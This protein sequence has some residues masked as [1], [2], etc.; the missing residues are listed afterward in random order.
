MINTS[1][2][3][4]PLFGSKHLIGL[5]FVALL[6]TALMIINKEKTDNANKKMILYL[7]I[8]FFV[9]EI[10]KLSFMTIRDS[11]FP[12]NHLPFHLCSLPLYLFPILYFVKKDSKVAKFVA[13]AA[14]AS[15]MIAA[16]AALAIPTNILGNNETW[17]SF[18]GNFLPLLSFIYHG[19]MIFAPVYLL[20]RGYYNIKLSDIP[21]AMLTTSALMVL[22]LIFNAL[23]DRD[24]MLLNTGNGSPLVFLLDNGQ[25]VY[26][27]SMMALGY[28]CI[29][30]VFLV[31]VGI[32][33]IKD[34][35]K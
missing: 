32:I 7:T 19:L 23:L 16:I 35:I 27:G 11:S 8:T 25:F 4:T 34:I 3:T 14:Y 9:L 20:N 15:V 31:T 17:F 26:T 29:A 10:I 6:V 12:M 18:D 28:I 21:K 2:L 24:Y 1:L 33:K 22:A 30:L 5:L 13:P